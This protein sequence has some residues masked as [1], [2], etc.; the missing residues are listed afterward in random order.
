MKKRSTAVLGS[1]LLLSGA[2][3]LTSCDDT[4]LPQAP[5][6]EELEGAEDQGEGADQP[7]DQDE[8]SGQQDGQEENEDRQDSR[9]EDQDEN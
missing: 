4:Q 3:F 6:V 7:E 5:A 8:G 1:T 2:L 9:D